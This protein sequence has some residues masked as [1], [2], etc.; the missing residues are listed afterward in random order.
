MLP[1]LCRQ[2]EAERGIKA[3]GDDETVLLRMDIML[4]AVAHYRAENV[5]MAEWR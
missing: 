2:P 5:C 1:E 4:G 3:S